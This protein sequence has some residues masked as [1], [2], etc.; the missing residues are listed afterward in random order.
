MKKLVLSLAITSALGLTACD[1]TTLQDVQAETAQ[2]RQSI[3]AAAVSKV[4]TPRVRVV[5]DPAGGALSVPNDLLFSGTTD[6]TLEMPAEV[7]SK[8][9]GEPVDFTNPEAALGALDGWGTQ[10]SFTV[11]L[12]YDDLNRDGMSDVSIDRSTLIPGAVSLYKVVK[13]P[14]IVD[15]E[16]TD[17]AMSGLLCKGVSEL[18]FGVDFV[19]TLSGDSIAIVPLKPFE[20]GSSYV[21]ALT[22]AV[23]DTNGNSLMPSSTYASIKADINATPLVLPT[24][25]SSELN[26]TQ[27]GIRLLQTMINNFEDVLEA[28]LGANGADIVYTQAFTVQSAGVPK[29]DPLQVAKQLNGQTFGAMA[30]ADPSSVAMPMTRVTTTVVVDEEGNTMDFD[31]TV[32]MA[33]AAAGQIENDPESLPYKLFNSANLF[34]S[35][36]DLPYYLEDGAASLSTRWKAA[37]D[38]GAMLATLS[39]E[40]K[41]ALAA[42][43]GPNHELC[44]QLGLADFGIDTARHLTKFNPVPAMQSMKTVPAQITVPNIDNANEVRPAFGLGNLV[45][46]E[47]GWPIVILQHGITSRK[48]DMLAATGF[49]SVMGF[50][51]VAIDHPLHGERGFMLENGM[52]INA[53]SAVEGS[54]PTN[55]L[56]LASLLTARD[57]QRQSIADALKLRLSLNAL[58]DMTNPEMP[59][60]A[61]IDSNDVHYLGHS[62]GAITGTAFTAI[63]NTPTVSEELDRLYKINSSVLSNPGGGVGN[64]LV[65]S[66]SFGPLVKASVIAGLGNELT[67]SMLALLSPQ[68]Y[69]AIVQANPA[70]GAALDA[71]FNVVDQNVALVCAFEAFMATASDAEKAGVAAGLAQFSFAAQTAVDAADPTNYA[72][73][74][75]ATQTP[76]LVYEMVGDIADEGLNKSDEVVPNFVTTNPIAGTSGLENV[77]G[78]TKITNCMM[79]E[80]P[81]Q[82]IAEFKYGS[83]STVLSPATALPE[84]YPTLFSA[85]N[86]EMLLMAST[87][88]ASDGKMVN[89]TATG[90]M[91]GV[92][93]GM[94][95]GACEAP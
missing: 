74:I 65:E 68:A 81:I 94:E 93:K 20:A 82:A 1:D 37:C 77:L 28:E 36:V 32:A 46:P 50:A 79:S 92:I 54:N 91:A 12:D 78:L 66:G 64:F 21:L 76:V 72:G 42:N 13:Y 85:V 45:K 34:S 48:E 62:L 26:A 23:K 29:S 15:P 38:S 86:Q 9:A 14:S 51:T 49:L 67:A 53:S 84:P 55:Y 17:S 71:E 31:V 18:T 22:N 90:R 59:N 3:E 30:G 43:A 8:E 6:G 69:G 52:N 24:I 7:A 35:S 44:A 33:L 89:I 73:L 11:A 61:V 87:F 75:K 4:T 16:C 56:N 40:Q 47:G 25:P 39:D 19:A 63:A 57:N 83:H 27:A 58:V 60:P 10:N 95:E 41:A 2:Q 88:F 5:F 80:T 70:C